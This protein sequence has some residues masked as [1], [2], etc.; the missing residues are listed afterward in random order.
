MYLTTIPLGNSRV[1]GSSVLVEIN[2]VY[3]TNPVMDVIFETAINVD[4]NAS[5]PAVMSPSGDCS[6]HLLP[7]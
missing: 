5:V 6:C 1:S 3:D 7:H 4:E 2:G